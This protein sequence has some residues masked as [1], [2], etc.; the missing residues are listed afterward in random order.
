MNEPDVLTCLVYDK[1]SQ[2][3]GKHIEIKSLRSESLKNIRH[4][5]KR[6]YIFLE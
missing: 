2:K 5:F 4:Y 6:H 1:I 3:C